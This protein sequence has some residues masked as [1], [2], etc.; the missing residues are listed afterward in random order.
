MAK[1]IAFF[2]PK[3]PNGKLVSVYGIHFSLKKTLS[4]LTKS[5]SKSVHMLYS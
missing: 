5:Q 2:I 1:I 3:I 4:F